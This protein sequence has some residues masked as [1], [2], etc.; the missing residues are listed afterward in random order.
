VLDIFNVEGAAVWKAEQTCT[1]PDIL[2]TEI[3]AIV[4]L[5]NKSGFEGDFVGEEIF[6]LAARLLSAVEVDDP[7]SDDP[8][9]RDRAEDLAY[10]LELADDVDGTTTPTAW[11]DRSTQRRLRPPHRHLDRHP[12]R[13]GRHHRAARPSADHEMG[14]GERRARARGEA[15]AGGTGA[16]TRAPVGRLLTAIQKPW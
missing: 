7:D 1:E 11:V 5:I 12:A 3:D 9:S 13:K 6:A 10:S 8:L 4:R 2:R 15:L 16:R 14:Y